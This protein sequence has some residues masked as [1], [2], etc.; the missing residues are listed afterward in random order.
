MLS[1]YLRLRLPRKEAAQCLRD[2]YNVHAGVLFS[3]LQRSVRP[4]LLLLLLT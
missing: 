1:E 2:R 4:I 3:N